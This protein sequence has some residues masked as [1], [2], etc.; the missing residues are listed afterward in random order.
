MVH[1]RENFVGKDFQSNMQS[2]SAY[3]MQIP[4][5]PDRTFRRRPRQHQDSPPGPSQEHLNVES[6][7]LTSPSQVCL[8]R[9]LLGM[10]YEGVMPGVICR[11]RK[12]I[13]FMP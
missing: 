11:E 9:T 12:L 6:I 2:T 3:T 13:P 5:T 7:H 8:M 4:V 1:V 10:K